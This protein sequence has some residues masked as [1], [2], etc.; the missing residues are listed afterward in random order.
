M[1]SIAHENEW[2]CGRSEKGRL[3]RDVRG[4]LKRFV[5]DSTWQHHANQKLSQDCVFHFVNDT[6]A[7]SCKHIISQDSSSF[8]AVAAMEL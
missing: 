5:L 4:R 7:K 3:S 2:L 8:V 6:L 1:S